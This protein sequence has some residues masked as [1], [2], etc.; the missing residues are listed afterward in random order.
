MSVRGAVLKI[1]LRLGINTI[2]AAK[3]KEERTAR[4]K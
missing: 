2:A 4:F 1:G 3:M